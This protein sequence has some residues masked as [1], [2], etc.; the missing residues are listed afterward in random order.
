MTHNVTA[1]VPARGGS[2]GVA[3]KNRR[4]IA[5]VPLIS[6][7]LRAARSAESLDR[8]VVTTDDPEIARIARDEGVEVVIRPPEIAGDASPVIEAVRHVLNALMERDG[9]TADVIVLLQ[10]TSPFRDSRDIDAA[11]ELFLANDRTPVCSV[12]RCEDNHPARMYRIEDDRLVA[13]FPDLASLRRQDLPPVFHRNGS[14]YVF[15]QPEVASGR[16]I[17]EGM[18]PYVMPASSSV[19]IDAEIDFVLMAAMLEQAREDPA[20][21]A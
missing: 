3:H 6:Y 19:N 1:I 13:L 9:Y 18:L 10:P 14:L 16:I 7:T 2:K 21:R 5:G 8:I 12:Y 20:S 4:E 15:G 17:G 11:V